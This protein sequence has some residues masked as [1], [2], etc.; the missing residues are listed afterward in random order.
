[1]KSPSK[2]MSDLVQKIY[3]N[4]GENPGTMLVHTGAIG[5]VLSSCAQIFAIAFPRTKNVFDTPRSR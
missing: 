1:M 4:Y 3:H 2:L 5:W